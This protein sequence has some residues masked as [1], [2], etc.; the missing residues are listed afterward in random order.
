MFFFFYMVIEKTILLRWN[1]QLLA[2]D[3][4]FKNL[5]YTLKTAWSQTRF[6]SLKVATPTPVRDILR[7]DVFI[8]ARQNAERKCICDINKCV[9]AAVVTQYQ[10]LPQ[11]LPYVTTNFYFISSPVF[12]CKWIE[13]W[14]AT[15]EFIVGL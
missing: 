12:S 4:N 5:F 7:Q 10:I 11:E 9:T 2:K 15:E 14:V 1:D 6:Q 3:I 13:R 8:R